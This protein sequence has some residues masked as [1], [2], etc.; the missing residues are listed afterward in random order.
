MHDRYIAEICRPRLSVL[1]L[2]L[3]VH[4]HSLLHVKS[5]V[6]YSASVVQGHFKVIKIDTS[7]SIAI[8][9]GK[10]EWCGYPK[11]KKFDDM[12]SCFEYWCVTDGHTDILRQHS[13]CYA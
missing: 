5:Y 8:W 9:Y 7:R 3:W 12:F 1:P 10:L 6:V 2:I 4:L 13:L 11:V